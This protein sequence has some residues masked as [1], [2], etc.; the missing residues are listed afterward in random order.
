MQ[1]SGQATEQLPALSDRGA[2]KEAEN[3]DMTV[4]FAHFANDQVLSV[5]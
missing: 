1:P 2:M 5:N 3:F 4:C